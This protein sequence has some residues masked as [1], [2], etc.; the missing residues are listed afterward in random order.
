M[1]FYDSSSNIKV[2]GPVAVKSVCAW[3]ACVGS[4]KSELAERQEL[5]GEK[6]Q[7]DRNRTSSPRIL[8]RSGQLE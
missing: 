4:W 7:A 1:I 2:E 8:D 5:S 3:T 6:G